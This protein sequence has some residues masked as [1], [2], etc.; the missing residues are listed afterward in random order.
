MTYNFGDSFDLYTAVADM[1]NGYWDSV[2]GSPTLTTTGRFAGSR[3]YSP[4]NGTVLT[5]T[6][7]VNDAVHHFALA[8]YQNGALSGTTATDSI[9]LFDG[10][11]AQCSVVFRSDGAI[12]L[13]SG[14]VGGTTLATYTGAITA[15]TTWFAFEI[16][17]SI[18]NTTGVFNVRK[19]GNTVN[20]FSATALNTRPTST[21]NYANKITINEGNAS[22]AQ[23]IDD[24][25]WQ[26]GA[27]TGTW[28]G[29]IRCYTRMPASDQSV[30]FSK[31]PATVTQAAPDNGTHTTMSGNASWS[32]YEPV[33]ASYDG[34]VGSVTVSINAG[35]TGNL[36]CSVFNDTAGVAGTVRA[37]A[38]ATMTNPPTGVAT[39]S[40]TP[41]A[42]SKGV[43][44]W[45]AFA[46]DG[47]YTNAF[48]VD[49]SSNG[50]VATAS[51][52]SVFPTASPGAS[53]TNNSIIS[54][55]TLAPSSNA[56]LVN[57]PQQDGA[58]SYVFDSNPGDADFYGLAGTAGTPASVVATTIRGYMTKPDAGTRIAAIQLQSGATT[59][60]TPPCVL[61]TSGFQW[62]WR[63]DVVDPNT[64][65]AWAPS[66]VNV[67]LIGPT[68][69]AKMPVRL[70]CTITTGRTA[71]P[72]SPTIAATR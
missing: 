24:F 11:T 19:N 29:D 2:S 54:G 8:I 59:V 4:V 61:T 37:S 36:K 60:A 39:F 13:Q 71:R 12:L 33:I 40:F 5:K 26:S 45:L 41:F 15:A 14:T 68:V 38:T 1:T 18:N 32:Y 65:A 6:S 49:N 20:D 55:W 47:A 17:V 66:S 16:E 23:F 25:Y 63:T 10:A 70:L 35:F 3:A 21:N 28:L 44:Y 34:T 69:T 52:Y 50:R 58:T 57:E 53:T 9:T 56:T 22:F 27:A 64:G 48:T 67:A 42:V 62:A 31:S 7:G 72:R 43:K 51:G 46:I 30:T